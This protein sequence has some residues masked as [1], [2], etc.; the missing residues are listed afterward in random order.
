MLAGESSSFCAEK[1]LGLL[2]LH[3]PGRFIPV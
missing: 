1:F 3:L 2:L